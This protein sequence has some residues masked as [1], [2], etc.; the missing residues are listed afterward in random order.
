MTIKI[1][2][3]KENK[4]YQRVLDQKFNGIVVPV[5]RYINPRAV[6]KHGCMRCSTIFYQKPIFLINTNNEYNHFCIV[7]KNSNKKRNYN[8]KRT[9]TVNEQLKG[10]MLTLFNQ[11]LSASEISKRLG[12][13]RDKVR[14]WLKKLVTR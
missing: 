9:S 2:Y 6:I 7:N 3:V 13:S 10:D 8:T 14:Y 12:I 5:E 1:G 4:E 11:G